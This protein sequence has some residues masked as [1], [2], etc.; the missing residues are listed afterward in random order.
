M[1][2]FFCFSPLRLAH[3]SELRFNHCADHM[4]FAMPQHLPKSI[5]KFEV[6]IGHAI[7]DRPALSLLAADT[8]SIWPQLEF[9]M[10]LVFLSMLRGDP[11][12]TAAVYTS[13]RNSNA[14]KDA[15][16]ALSEIALTD[17]EDRDILAGL[18]RRYTGSAKVRDVLAHH[19]WGTIP[20]YPDALLMVNPR[21]MAATYTKFRGAEVTE[22]FSNEKALDMINVMRDSIQVWK[23]D[24]FIEAHDRIARTIV[25]ATSFTIMMP[26]SQRQSR[27]EKARQQLLSDHDIGEYVRSAAEKRKKP[28]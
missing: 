24:D 28:L 26:N 14:Q 13:I 11:A 15:F 7:E 25:M 1:W 19:V 12:P 18:L 9:S 10:A 8:L 20:D 4:G 3:G 17:Q 27:D 22:S 5:T 2:R 23:A 6:R 21:G 16:K